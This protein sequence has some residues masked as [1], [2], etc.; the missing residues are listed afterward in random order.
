[1]P[2]FAAGASFYSQGSYPLAPRLMLLDEAFAGIDDTARAH[3]MGLI[4]L[5]RRVEA[6]LQRLLASAITRSQLAAEVLGD[7]HA[8]DSGQPTA[9]LVLKVWR[10]VIARTDDNND[11]VDI[12]P[13]GDGELEP[14][15]GAER[16]RD[17]WAN[18]GV[19]VNELARP[20]LFLN[21]PMHD[22]GNHSQSHGEPV[23]ASLR[24]LLRSPPSWDV[25]NSNVYLCENPNVVAIARITWGSHCAPL[26]CT[27]GMPPQHSVACC[28]NWLKRVRSF[29]IM[30]ISIGRDTD[31][32]PRHARA[33]RPILALWRDRLRGRRRWGLRSWTGSHGKGCPR[34]AERRVDDGHAATSVLH[35]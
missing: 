22:A 12:E 13:T 18:A 15:G 17:V 5:C 31:R 25:A 27:D 28:R 29:A 6:V 11:D 26:V 24:S 19:L 1:M 30:A 33:R 10:Q 9:T 8:F 7:A 34:I 23:Y 3:C 16:D 32:Q 20:V 35:C 21:R 14:G 2:L 4:R